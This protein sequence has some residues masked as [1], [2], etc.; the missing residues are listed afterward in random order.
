MNIF[1][2]ILA[3]IFI[4]A[5]ALG[6]FVKSENEKR[7]KESALRASEDALVKAG[8]NKIIES[9][10]AAVRE[11]SDAQ[12][13]KFHYVYGEQVDITDSGFLYRVKVSDASTEPGTITMLC[14]TKVGGQVVR[15]V[16]EN[17]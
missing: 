15:L 7:E 17:R 16:P 13:I 8:E 1:K 9:C 2:N 4:G 6:F 11:K 12:T 3:I 14:Y 10:K 5:I